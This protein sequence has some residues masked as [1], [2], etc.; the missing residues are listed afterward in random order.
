MGRVPAAGGGPPAKAGRHGHA[1]R[2]CRRDPCRDAGRT[3]HPRPP[4]REQSGPAAAWRAHLC[5]GLAAVLG[6]PPPRETV[7]CGRS[8]Y[9]R[10]SCGVS[11]A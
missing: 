10:E 2:P 4:G 3:D 7:S 9:A 5:E 1:E 6:E 8:G 11:E